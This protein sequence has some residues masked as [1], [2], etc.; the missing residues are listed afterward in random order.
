MA[1]V[2]SWPHGSSVVTSVTAPGRPEIRVWWNL[3]AATLTT[4]TEQPSGMFGVTG[5]QEGVR[6]VVAA[7]APVT[8]ARE[9][10]G[11]R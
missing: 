8:E 9:A 11:R 2:K 5:K 10:A 1:T 7:M 3:K 6:D 4:L